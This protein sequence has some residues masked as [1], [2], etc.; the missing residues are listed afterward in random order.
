MSGSGNLTANGT[1]VKSLNGSGASSAADTGCGNQ[2]VA[3]SSQYYGLTG[4]QWIII[5]ACLA[6]FGLLLLILVIVLG[7]LLSITRK[8]YIVQKGENANFH[9]E[10]GTIDSVDAASTSSSHFGRPIH[11]K[12]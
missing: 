6:A 8:R 3:S 10:S 7:C 4:N 9:S 1:S 11:H 2:A 5:V 12:V